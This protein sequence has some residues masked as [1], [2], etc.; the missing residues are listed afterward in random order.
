MMINIHR[1]LDLLMPQS[2]HN[3]INIAV[4]HVADDRK[5]VSKLMWRDSFLACLDRQNRHLLDLIPLTWSQSKTDGTL[6]TGCLATVVHRCPLESLPQEAAFSGIAQCYPS[7]YHEAGYPA[8]YCP[9]RSHAGKS[10]R[11]SVK[12]VPSENIRRNSFPF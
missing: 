6:S 1:C 5:A 10:L 12:T 11:R 2:P 9:S 8:V 4:V 3:R 7:P